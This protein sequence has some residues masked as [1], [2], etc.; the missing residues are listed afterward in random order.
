[1]SAMTPIQVAGAPR[2]LGHYSQAIVA[3]GF[4]FVAGQVPVDMDTGQA[5]VGT[6]EEQTELVLANT[7]RILGAAGSSLAQVVQM[8]VFLARMEDWAAVNAVYS[9]VLGDHRPARAI[10]PVNPLH[11]GA[12]IELQCIAIGP[13]PR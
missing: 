7:A 2:P 9:R 8:T 3:N 12:G 1:M 4:V 6:I 5:R 10:V 13:G 11:H